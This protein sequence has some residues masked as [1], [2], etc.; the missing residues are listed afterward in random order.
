MPRRL[1]TSTG[2]DTPGLRRIRAITSPAS[3]NCGT[4]F[5]LT[6]LVVSMTDSPASLSRSMNATL[7]SVSIG[8]GSFCKP[9]RGPTST[10]LMRCGYAIT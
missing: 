1:G 9:S 10:I 8:I 7:A 6:K 3:A 2:Y 5:G 4:Q